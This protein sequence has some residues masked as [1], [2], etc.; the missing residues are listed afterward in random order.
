MKRK[1]PSIPRRVKR[2]AA[3][4]GGYYV[5]GAPGSF[6]AAKAYDVLDPE[7]KMPKKSQTVKAVAN[8]TAISTRGVVAVRHKKKGVTNKKPKEVKVTK[9]FRKKVERALEKEG[10]RFH[11]S[12]RTFSY[13]QLPTTAANYPDGTQR[14]DIPG[15]NGTIFTSDAWGALGNVQDW[16]HQVSVL[17]NGKIDSQTSRNFYDPGTLLL[18]TNN[19]T[20][21]S[22]RQPVGVM[23]NQSLPLE[24]TVKKSYEKYRIKNNSQ[25]TVKFKIYLCAPKRV[26]SESVGISTDTATTSNEFPVS[27]PPRAAWF[28]AM[29][30]AQHQGVNISA[31]SPN[32]LYSSPLQCPQFKNLYKAEE[33][34]VILEPGQTYEYLIQGPSELKVNCANYFLGGGFM[35][36]Q[37]F[38]RFPMFVSH[39]DLVY[40]ATGSDSRIGGTGTAGL[41]FEREKFASFVIPEGVGA[42]INFP[43]LGSN[44]IISENMKGNRFVHKVYTTGLSGAATRI[45][46]EVPGAAETV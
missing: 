33:T 31:A 19:T 18:N 9:N 1:L 35:D 34:T 10:M 3:E 15:V 40:G 21:P 8:D 4:M 14:V 46:E 2:F 20:G 16:I 5:G 45:D 6:I 43:S 7:K 42:N 12:F 29:F 39:L 36:L 25:R 27:G 30:I 26:T 41:S 11:G 23:S 28:N 44:A 13:W 24:F 17:W 38:A 22:N 37:K 32:A